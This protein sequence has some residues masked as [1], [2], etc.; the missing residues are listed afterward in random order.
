MDNIF[1]NNFIY[2]LWNSIVRISFDA[3]FC[4][5]TFVT[6]WGNVW[7]TFVTIFDIDHVLTHARTE[8]L[9]NVYFGNTSQLP[10]D[11]LKTY[12]CGPIKK[13]I[14]SLKSTKVSL[15]LEWAKYKIFLGKGR[16]PL[17]PPPEGCKD[18]CELLTHSEVW[19]YLDAIAGWVF[20]PW[21]F[22]ALAYWTRTP[23]HR[24]LWTSHSQSVLHTI[25]NGMT[26]M[27]NHAQKGG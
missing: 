6:F 14:F 17:K 1:T 11:D 10:S 24:I 12:L 5:V 23:P 27:H 20:I 15:S 9:N 7:V 4:L 26:P 21:Q 13:L 18:H 8:N 25:Q 19:Q 16:C 22:Q 2:F 3:T